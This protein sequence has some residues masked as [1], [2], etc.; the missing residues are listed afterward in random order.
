MA[1]RNAIANISFTVDSASEDEMTY[2][3]LNALPTPDSNTE[4]KAPTR[5]AR[6][7]P[8]VSAAAIKAT[9]KSKPAARRV[10]AG[11]AAGAKRTAKVT[12]KAP[13]K[14]GR[15]ALA[16]RS[17]NN[18]SDTEEVDE[19]DQDE[20]AEP[21][22]PT[23]RSRLTGKKAQEEAEPEAPVPVKRG[24][25]VVAKEAPAK[26]T[27]AKAN[28]KAKTSRIAA[29]PETVPETQPD[30]DVDA[31]DI[32]ES[33]EIEEIPESMPPPPRPS[34]RRTQVQARGARQTSRAGSASDSER[35][36]ALRRKLGDI[37][38]KLEAMTVK[39]EA[40]KETASSGKD[41]NFEQLRKRTEQTARG[42]SRLTDAASTVR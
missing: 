7:Q 9:A 39:Y 16:E 2:D 15:K 22:K 31:M 42:M 24:R 30:Q 13:A 35:D 14:G 21:V 19:F 3:E 29:E 34:A 17:Q 20:T 26:E 10:S 4:N 8:K 32:E 41:S 36:P 18:A 38:R 33:V 40:L 6:A 12:K 5:K 1:P 37:T 28:T 25:K 23:K 27:K 11:S